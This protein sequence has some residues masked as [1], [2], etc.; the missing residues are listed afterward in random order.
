MHCLLKYMYI[1]TYIQ[2]N[3]LKFFLNFLAPFSVCCQLYVLYRVCVCVRTCVC[4]CRYIY[5]QQKSRW[6]T[7]WMV[8]STLTACSVQ[9]QRRKKEERR[10]EKR[11]KSHFFFPLF[12]FFALLLH[13]LK[14]AC[15]RVWRE[16]KEERKTRRWNW[17]KRRAQ[18]QQLWLYTS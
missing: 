2:L 6:P 10:D 3:S 1:H 9:L 13:N 15:L 12:F 7:G 17:L 16:H 14:S 4:T 8:W 18:Q 5:I 11:A